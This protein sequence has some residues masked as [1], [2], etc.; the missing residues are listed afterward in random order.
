MDVLLA[1]YSDSL[2]KV[3]AIMQMSSAG[4]ADKLKSINVYLLCALHY[5]M[6]L[7]VRKYYLG[8]Q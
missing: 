6:K 5:K 4:R 8:G 1:R 3:L 2:T 7:Q